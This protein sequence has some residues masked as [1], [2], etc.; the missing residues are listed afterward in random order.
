MAHWMY[1]CN[2][3]KLDHNAYTGD[4][5]SVFGEDKPRTWGSTKVVP[6][7]GLLRV[8]DTVLAYQTDKNLLVGVARVSGWNK[9]RVELTPVARIGKKVRPL[10]SRY[11]P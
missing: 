7:L 4:W 6:Q 11:L 5:E 10:K 3:K 1:K 8:D 9:D 2:N